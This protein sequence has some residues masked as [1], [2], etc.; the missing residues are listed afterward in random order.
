MISHQLAQVN[1][2]R[3]LAPFDSAELADYTSRVEPL[4]TLADGSPGFVWRLQSDTGDATSIQ[5]YEDPMILI[6]LSV[7]EDIET[8][9]AYTYRSDHATIMKRRREWFAKIK[10]VTLA[11]WWIK[12]GSLPT[13]EQARQR[14]DCLNQHGPTPFAFTFKTLFNPPV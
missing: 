6:N 14:L 11:L 4:N 2:V 3:L 12:S 9:K 5:A 7:W 10:S 8:L 13:V 1:I